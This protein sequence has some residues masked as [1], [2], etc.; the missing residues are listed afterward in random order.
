MIAPQRVVKLQRRI[1]EYR[2]AQPFIGR[3]TKHGAPSAYGFS[4][5]TGEMEEDYGDKFSVSTGQMALDLELLM[6]GY[7]V[8]DGVFGLDFDAP[9]EGFSVSTGEFSA[10]LIAALVNYACY[11]LNMDTKGVYQFNN[12]AFYGLG[13]F[14]NK[15]IGAIGNNILD[16]ESLATQDITTNITA[17]FEV[18]TDFSLAENKAMRNI[19][20][21]A[22]P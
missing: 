18:E 5:S 9:A 10:E 11:V 3:I 14:N 17:Y 21:H 13:R 4:A 22:A 19:A 15:L 16:L 1:P 8:S 20:E 6:S 2:T 7:S 12:Y